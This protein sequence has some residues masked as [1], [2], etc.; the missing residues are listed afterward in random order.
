MDLFPKH[1]NELSD[2]ARPKRLQAYT[3]LL[4]LCSDGKLTEGK[5]FD[6]LRSCLRGFE[7]SAERCREYAIQIV[8]SILVRQ[9]PSV[10][11][12]VLPAVVT[13]I[14]VSPVA[15]ESEELRLL[16]LRLAVLCM[17]TFPHEIGPRNYIDF[18]QVLLENCLRDA[19]P[20]L[21]KEACRAC[22]RLCEIEPVQVKHVSLP[23]AK[24]VK[25]CLLHKHSVVRAEAARTLASLIQR[26]AV[27]ILADG[28]DE[29][30]NRTTAYTLFVLANDHAE[31]VRSALVDLLSM[32]LLDI[33][34]R[35]DQHRRLLPHLL[36]LVTDHFPAVSEKA[37]QV[38]ENMGKQYLLDNEDNTIDI[39]KRRV[40]M[41]DIEWYGDEEYPDMSLT[42]V[43][44]SLYPVLR[45][46][47]S[48]GARYVVAESLRGFIETVF[49]DVCAIDW[50]VPFSS[51][52][53]RVVALR[54]LWMSIYHTEKS[55]VQFVEQILGVLYKSLRDSQD[56]VQE[57]LICLEILG[58]FLT[59][60]Q[61][62]PFLTSKEAPKESE[63]SQPTVIQSRSKTV[64]ISSANG[65]ATNSPTLFST[66]A[67]SVKCSILVAFRYLIE[68]S[69]SLLSATNATHIVS[70]MTKSDVLESDSEALLCSLLDTL[71]V[72]IKVLGERDFVATPD[73]PLP[74]EVRDD[75]NQRTLDS[76]LLY[77]FLCLRSSSFP[78]VQERV[79]KCT[80]HLSTVVTGQP[81]AIYDL[82]FKR[83]LSRYGTRM[84]VSAFSDLVLSSSNIGMYGEQLSNIFLLKLSD[85]D[86]TQRVTDCLQYM[87]ML[88]ELLWRK[89]P[90]FSGRQLE[91]VLRVVILPLGAFRPGGQAHLFRKV[92]VSSQC[93]LLQ[94][95]HRKLLEPSLCDNAFA[96]SSKVVTNWCNASDADDP[97]M[98]LMCMVNVPNLSYLPI[99]AGS[100]S[101]ILQSIILRFDDSNDMIRAK[102]AS[103]L[104]AI[105]ENKNEVCP[106]VI[107]EILSQATPLLKKLLIH[108]DDHDE[109]VGLKPILVGVLKETAIL[110]P[111]VTKDLVM[112][113]MAKHQVPDY[114]QEVL[115]FIESL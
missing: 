40:T 99:N 33:Q 101:D 27:E 91:E 21:K 34:E 106:I 64:V 57:S 98:R 29:P 80:A 59:P 81:G 51:N 35:Q 78:S 43:D 30:A 112:D 19:Y 24:V 1:L 53:R 86:F 65:E 6:L 3:K 20:D 109:T 52:N 46:R 79:S 68:G 75:V 70:A 66:A 73:N 5:E 84:P 69:K 25:N 7:D 12:W 87:R 45:R 8:S 10:L 47:P 92:A 60:D 74:Q 39:T 103:G 55:V 38:L 11:D 54:I 104:L 77:A 105:L 89:V 26:G 82:H 14:G 110:A 36:L 67:A 102:A 96:L 31:V 113:A 17:E 90:V 50:V 63:A 23:L 22:V 61:Y 76:V 85:I 49:A 18:L 16:L 15:E 37:L 41:K 9:P 13:R 83:I 94:E 48:L 100:A 97:E 28:K 111:S 32:S 107:D 71:D 56:V 88:E 72:V 93:A 95:W 2:V 58:K 42:T 108:L 115:L 4:D 62:L 114:C 44:T